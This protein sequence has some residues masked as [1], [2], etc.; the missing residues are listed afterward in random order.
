M[1]RKKKPSM[2]AIRSGLR[3]KRSESL[4][5]WVMTSIRTTIVAMRMS[6]PWDSL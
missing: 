3:P 1:E 2:P 4:P 6:R 5:T